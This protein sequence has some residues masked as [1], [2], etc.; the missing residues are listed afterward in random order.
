MASLLVAQ[1]KKSTTV[2]KIWV[3][4][5]ISRHNTLKSKYNRKYDY[6]RAQCEDPELIREWF[7]RV[8]S[9]IIEYGI[10]DDDIYNFDE[11]GFQM[12]VISTAKVVTGADRAGRPRTTQPGNREWVTVIETINASGFAIPPLV[13]FEAVMHQAGWYNTLPSDW[14]I[15]VSENGWTNNEIG[16]IWLKDIFDKHTKNR[17]VGRYRLLIF[18]GHGSHIT[19]EF[20]QYCLQ[21]SIVVLCMPPHSSHL[22]QPLDVGCFSVLKGS[23]GRSVGQLMSLGVNHIDKQEFISLYQQA[24]MEALHEKNIKSGFTATG[25]VPYKPDQVLSLLNSQLHTPSPQRLPPNQPVWTAETP[26][27]IIEL[28]HQTELIKQ[29]L[30]R[31]TQSPPSP[32]ERAVN[33]LIKGC[34]LA[35]NSAVLLAHQNDQLYKENR[36]QK[37]KR[38]QRRSYISKGG[39]LQGLKHNSL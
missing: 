21:H 11:T 34:Q 14:S 32:T 15:T 4:N 16:L 35:M 19:P 5:F 24:R 3:R 17:V 8:Q 36:R 33:Q 30:R 7:K 10:V 28:Q 18:D 20:D 27:N 29:Y 37:Q 26:H 31:R 13:I 25:L 1:H 39:S 22:L 23:Y 2:G 12:G 9:T 6:Q 38:A